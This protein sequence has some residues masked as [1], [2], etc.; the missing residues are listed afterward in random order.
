MKS[1]YYFIMFK[2]PGAKDSNRVFMGICAPDTCTA[3]DI[4]LEI[5]QIFAAGNIPLQTYSVTTPSTYEYP[6]D[7]L[8]WFTVCWLGLLGFLFVLSTIIKAFM[9]NRT[10]KFVNCFALQ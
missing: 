4:S 5:D 2:T 8:F 10:N 1:I 3:A 7:W 6:K 9:K